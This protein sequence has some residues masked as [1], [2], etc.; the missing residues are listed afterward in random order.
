MARHKAAYKK[1]AM[2]AG[3]DTDAIKTDMTDDLEKL[4]GNQLQNIRN[5]RQ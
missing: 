1:S 2:E 3:K 5:L 4:A